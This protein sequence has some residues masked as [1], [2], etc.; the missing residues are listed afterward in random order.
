[1]NESLGWT[2]ENWDVLEPDDS[3]A[4]APEVDG[5]QPS[6]EDLEFY[7]DLLRADLDPCSA[8]EER[9]DPLDEGDQDRPIDDYKLPPPK[10]WMVNWRDYL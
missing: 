6:D 10:D 7:T 5:S 2:P 1:M 8:H 3:G 4:A 9:P